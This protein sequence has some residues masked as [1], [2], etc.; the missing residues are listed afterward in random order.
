MS[1]VVQ[2]ACTVC[3]DRWEELARTGRKPTRCPDC[4]PVAA[5]TSAASFCAGSWPSSSWPPA[6]AR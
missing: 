1:G 6:A 4:D 5:P 3:G 2:H